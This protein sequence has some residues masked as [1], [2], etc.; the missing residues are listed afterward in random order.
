MFFSFFYVD[1]EG[2]K[3]SSALGAYGCQLCFVLVLWLHNFCCFVSAQCGRIICFHALSS[4]GTL[5]LYMYI[6]NPI[7][8]LV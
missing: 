2:K 1:Q 7:L 3:I 5:H 8:G 4:P 6:T